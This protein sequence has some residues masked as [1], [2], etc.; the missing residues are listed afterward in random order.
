LQPFG[1]GAITGALGLSYPY[2]PPDNGRHY[3]RCP[4]GIARHPT[5]LLKALFTRPPS[6]T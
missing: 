6:R 2:A 5:G 3:P 4:T 1:T